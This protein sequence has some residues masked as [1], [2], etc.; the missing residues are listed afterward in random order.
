MSSVTDVP[1]MATI[2]A[3]AREKLAR[4]ISSLES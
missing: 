4:A 3:E 1:E 2:A